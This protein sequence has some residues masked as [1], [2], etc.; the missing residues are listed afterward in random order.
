MAVVDNVEEGLI[1][2]SEDVVAP[3]GDAHQLGAGLQALAE[4]GWQLSDNAG[5]LV[6][7][8]VNDVHAEGRLEV[9]DDSLKLISDRG[10]VPNALLHANDVVI[11][12][13]FGNEALGERG[14]LGGCES[15]ERGLGR[16]Q[17]RSDN[18]GSGLLLA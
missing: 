8:V 3:L 11:A 14:G 9:D 18:G 12:D 17:A 7:H 16:A 15:N 13:Q 5:K 2:G 4:V 10:L 1:G 6:Q